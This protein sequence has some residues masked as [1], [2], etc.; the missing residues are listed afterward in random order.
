M[1]MMNS[2]INPLIYAWKNS[3]FR[4]AFW[5]MIRCKSPNKNSPTEEYVTNHLPVISSM[6]RPTLTSIAK[7]AD[8]TSNHTE[9]EM[10]D[11]KSHTEESKEW[12]Q[13]STDNTTITTGSFTLPR[14]THNHI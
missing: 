10:F 14:D 11:G 12:D 13:E 5:C 3:N 8:T 2:S 7:Y 6:K 4:K 1:A 9:F